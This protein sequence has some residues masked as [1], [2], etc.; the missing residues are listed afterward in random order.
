MERNKRGNCSE[1]LE[2]ISAVGSGSW[3]IYIMSHMFFFVSGVLF[4]VGHRVP[5]GQRDDMLHNGQSLVS[6]CVCAAFITIV[7][8]LTSSL[9]RVHA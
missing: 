6:R 2:V 5:G 1:F 3:Q 9:P 7:N 4:L 8:A